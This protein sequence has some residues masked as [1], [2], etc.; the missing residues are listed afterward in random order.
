ML[1]RP[2]ARAARRAAPAGPRRVPDRPTSRDDAGRSRPRRR[3]PTG[4]RDRSRATPR[5]R[6]PRRRAGRRPPPAVDPE[7]DD[8]VAG[9]QPAGRV[10]VDH[11]G[12]PRPRHAGQRRR[13]RRPGRAPGPRAATATAPLAVWHPVQDVSHALQLHRIR[14]LADR[15]VGDDGDDDA[16]DPAPVDPRQ[17]A[18]AR[19]ATEP[20]RPPR[21]PRREAGRSDAAPAPSSCAPRP[22]TS[23]CGCGS[24]ATRWPR[25]SAPPWPTAAGATG[26]V[27]PR[28][29]TRWRRA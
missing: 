11:R 29:T 10:L 17:P 8:L 23:R 21:R 9:R 4:R 5:R 12:D 2:A 28:S 1:G 3:P 19:P 7:H 15:L 27:D 22:P 14:Q 25:C 13:A 20:A 6:R 26:L 18:V 24:G 16:S